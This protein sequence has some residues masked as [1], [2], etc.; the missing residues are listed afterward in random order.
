MGLEALLIAG[1]GIAAGVGGGIGIS[2]LAGGGSK[3]GAPEAPK[4]LP[5]AP[6]VADAEAKAEE[7][8]RK[9]RSQQTQTVFTDPL[10]VA[11]QAQ[12]ARK[13]LTGQ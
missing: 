5:A 1:L 11:G 8:V 2:K 3:G 12:V 7:S 4:P 10:G 9:R 6:N 13:T